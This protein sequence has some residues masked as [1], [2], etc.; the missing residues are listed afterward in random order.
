MSEDK[1]YTM[2]EIVEIVGKLPVFFDVDDPRNKTT[3]RDYG[4]MIIESIQTELMM[5]DEGADPSNTLDFI[6]PSNTL[7]FIDA[8]RTK[9]DFVSE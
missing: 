1:K 6:D 5:V 4:R 8:S 9:G 3:K 7:D 2:K